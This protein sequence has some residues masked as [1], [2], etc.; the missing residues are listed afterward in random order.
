MGNKSIETA[1]GWM[2]RT[3]K[4]GIYNFSALMGFCVEA[5]AYWT[6]TNRTGKTMPLLAGAAATS[7]ARVASPGR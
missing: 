5:E 7:R 4:A 2:H 3:H 1:H 6:E